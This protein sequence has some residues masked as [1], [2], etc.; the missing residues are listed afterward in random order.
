[1]NLPTGT[2]TFLLTD[3]EGSAKLWELHPEAMRVALTR[4]DALAADIIARHGGVLIKHRGE[5]DSLFAVF[6]RAADALAAVCALQRAYVAEPWPGYAEEE[7]G[8]RRAESDPFAPA[9]F[10]LRVRMALHTGEADL[11]DGDYFGPVV[12]RCAR[13]RAIAHGGQI[14][15]SEAT[16][17]LASGNL[18][19]GVVLQDTGLHR[20]RDLQQPERVYQL[21]HPELPSDFPRL[22]SLDT[23]PN[24]LPRQLTSFV[25]RES[26]MAEVKRLLAQNCLLTLTGTG[27]LGK[28]RLALQ[29]A[30]DILEDYSDGVWLVALEALSDPALVPQA[31]AYALGVRE[32][33]GRQLTQTL[34]DYAKAKTLLLI[35]DNCEHLLTACAELADSLLRAC[36]NLRILANSREP[37]SIGGEF[38]YRVPPLSLPDPKR[39]PSREQLAQF[40]AVKLFL[41]RAYAALPS[42]SMTDR[43]AVAVSQVCHQL[44][45]IPL[46]I[47]LA[48]ARIKSLPVEQIATRL[49]DR[50]RLLTGGS[51][52]A[53]PRQQTLRALFDWSYDL[54]SDREREL[55]HRLSVFAGGL[56]LD[57]AEEVCADK[58]IGGRLRDDF[59]LLPPSALILLPFDLLDL[60]SQLVDKSLLVAEEQEGRVRYRLLETLRQYGREKLDESGL[61]AVMQRRQFL[62]YLNLAEEAERKVRGSE[63]AWWLER[64]DMEH[65]NLRA[66][67]A[68]CLE[69]R[70]EASGR[71]EEEKRGAQAASLMPE[72]G[73]RLAGALWWFWHV[74]GYFT[75]GREWLEAMLARATERMSDRAKALNGAAVLARNQGDYAAARALSQESLSIKRELGDVQGIAASLNNLATLALSQGDYATAKPYYED[76]LEMERSLGNRQG[77]TASLIG[78]GNVAL[79]Q[80][81]YARADALFAESLRIKRELGDRRGIAASLFGLGSAAFVQGDYARARQMHEEALTIRRNLREKRGIGASLQHLGHLAAAEGGYAKAEDQLAESLA[82]RRELGDKLGIAH[83]LFAQGSLAREQGD[84]R[85]AHALYAESL[86]IFRE[87]SNRRS[88][89]SALQAIASLEIAQARAEDCPEEE[90][91]RSRAL[92]AARLFGVEESLREAIGSPLHPNERAGYER[93]VATVRAV[94][95]EEMFAAWAEGCAGTPEEAITLA[96]E[97]GRESSSGIDEGR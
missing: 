28:T 97:R 24:N 69:D 34:V 62:H 91:R 67:L 10:A 46:A 65:D 36:P 47:E 32:E 19:F 86:T 63:Q 93:D 89:A 7:G 51:R 90:Q 73:L 77:I 16:Q 17:Q 5:G 49:D 53:L 61:T 78:L 35:L 82:I 54:L 76:S 48:A 57:A 45:G 1:V 94:L 8:S 4:H 56:T 59:P 64:L 84:V 13:L 3:V 92:R 9:A 26:E 20:L 37:L 22:R 85:T 88:I 58:D 66:A 52:T 96:L 25:G 74:R 60:L 75:E 11:R 21:W 27:G 14:L 38:I 70:Q 71:R 23:L 18:P 72:Q 33:A 2:V 6:A 55:F 44:D 29:V 31:V 41:D 40:E 81:E 30:A 39:L 42:F 68:W 15:L 80:G 79:E 83:T 95:G 43:N 87:L 50:F 12:N